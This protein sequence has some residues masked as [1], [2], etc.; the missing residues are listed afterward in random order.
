LDVEP[1]DR[2]AAASTAVRDRANAMLAQDIDPG[3][4]QRYPAVV[5]PT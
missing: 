3:F 1:A 5:H 4:Q 2:P